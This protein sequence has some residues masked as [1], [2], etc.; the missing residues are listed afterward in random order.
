[1]VGP[2][3]PATT[4]WV[5]QWT[6]NN[7]G[8]TGPQGPIGPTGPTGPS[9][10]AS[11]VPGPA[12]P[13][14]PI[15]NTGPTGNTGAQGPKGD[16][17]ATGPAGATGPQGIQGPTGPQGPQGTI[18][19]HHATH[20]PGGNDQI[21]NVDASKLTSGIIPNARYAADITITGSFN[22]ANIGAS[23]AYYEA[24]R[25][26]PQG[27]PNSVPFNAANFSNGWTVAAGNVVVNQYS[28]VGKTGTYTCYVSNS[29]V[30]GATLI[31]TNPMPG[32]NLGGSGA[33]M[34]NMVIGGVNESGNAVAVGDGNIYISRYAGQ[35]FPTGVLTRLLVTITMILP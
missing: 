31:L 13:Q 8:A 4:N 29:S 17:G 34:V 25:A 28:L 3:D 14:G 6:P 19:P 22:A 26:Q 23:G 2:P 35:A 7:V 16:T 10:P 9:G 1:M 30:S 33:G 18:A 12:G 5:P 24:S 20:E 21:L 27:Y 32:S 11:T 15:G